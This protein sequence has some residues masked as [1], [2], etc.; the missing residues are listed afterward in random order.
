MTP[1]TF[2]SQIMVRIRVYHCLYLKLIT[3][4]NPITHYIDFNDLIYKSLSSIG[5]DSSFSLDS[6]LMDS[7][8]NFG[9][10]PPSDDLAACF[11]MLGVNSPTRSNMECLS[12]DTVQSA[13]YSVISSPP[14]LF[15]FGSP[16]SQEPA[17]ATAQ[18]FTNLSL[19][20][21][22]GSLQSNFTDDHNMQLK[23]ELAEMLPQQNIP[24]NNC[25]GAFF[26]FLS[27]SPCFVDNNQM[28]PE[29]N[30]SNLSS[31]NEFETMGFPDISLFSQPSSPLPEN[32]LTTD[33]GTIPE[34]DCCSSPPQ[35][36][37]NLASDP[38]VNFES[39]FNA[40]TDLNFYPDL[41]DSEWH[42]GIA[43]NSAQ[44]PSAAYPPQDNALF[45]SQEQQKQLAEFFSGYFR[46]VST[47]HT[48]SATGKQT[49]VYKC[50]F[51]NHTSN[52]GNN[53]REHVQIHNPNRPKPFMCTLC[54]RFFAR[55]HDMNRHYLSCKKQNDKK[56]LNNVVHLS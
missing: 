31:C 27:V 55:K 53:M 51:C 13:E 16:A 54:K 40:A 4:N 26:D 30:D 2:Q 35:T 49:K 3:N 12:P 7:Y 11:D 20:S 17:A 29:N 52:R 22:A 45:Q 10:R 8:E 38:L 39:L 37:Q 42:T 33:T 6:V 14:P 47:I 44:L 19:N 28:V 18:F 43:P 46:P 15:H 34:Y 41:A 23:L 24:K 32:E 36:P 9:S 1:S 56:I 50:P 48:S 21:M 5:S 25:N